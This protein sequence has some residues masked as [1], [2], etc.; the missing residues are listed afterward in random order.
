MRLLHTSDWHLGRSLASAPQLDAQA[1]F[2]TW[3]LELAVE[4]EVDAVLVAGDV[5]DRAVPPVEAVRLLDDT[6]LA[7]AS[8]GVPLV[9]VSGNHDSA[10]RLGF[11]RGLARASGIHLRTTLDAL[12]DPVVLADEHGDVGVYGIPYLLPDAVMAEL[13][14][15][16]SHTSV[17]RAA[18]D[19]IR[20]DA[21]QRGLSRTVV[22]SHAF[23]A[24]GAGA[25]S[26]RDIRVGGIGDAHAAVFDGITYVALGHLHR[27]Q[28]IRL[29]GSST[30][31]RYSGSPLPYSFSESGDV[32]SVTLLE[33]DDAGVAV[34]EAVPVPAGRPLRE[35]RGRLEELLA[36]AGTDLAGLAECYVRVVLS[37]PSRPASPM[38]R[39]RA[40][41][42][43][44]LVLD[45]EPDGVRPDPDTDLARLT[46]TTDPV[47]VCSLFVEFVD[48]VPPTADEVRVLREV[49]ELA[50]RG[51]EAGV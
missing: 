20:A 25:D 32:K 48:R 47:E 21:A 11:G 46:R 45:F 9:V 42:P 40:V 26:E 16:R 17:L 13:A 41:W 37:D 28:D 24:G 19:R 44:T 27:P 2:L 30:V 39:L 12:T 8:A 33:L 29:G 35:V 14:A 18:A 31:L 38:E 3:L 51:E 22:L 4:R 1:E 6:F 7:F 5:Y 23:V 34:V 50:Q 49:V 36:R 10:V 43:H 15:E